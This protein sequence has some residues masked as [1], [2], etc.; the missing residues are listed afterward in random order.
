MKTHAF[1][2]S[3]NR[4]TNP[5][6]ATGDEHAVAPT[7]PG[8]ALLEIVASE[9]QE[10]QRLDRALTAAQPGMSR[11][12][13]QA[14]IDAGQVTVNDRLAKASLVLEP[15]MRIRVAPAVAVERTQ[16][17]AA[18][19]PPLRIV[20]EDAQL[21]VIDKPA[22][23]VVHPAPG[24][25]TGT[26]VDSLLAHMPDLDAGEDTT[27]PGI[28][29]RLDKDTSGLLVV[30]RD[31]ASHAALA[32]QMK[33]HETVKRYLALVEGTMTQAEGVIDAP[34]GRDPR[35]RQ[36]MGLVRVAS[37]GREARTRFRV[38]RSARGRTLLD[39]QLETGRTHQIRVHLAAVQHPVV[40]DLVYGRAQPPQPPRQF[41]H[42]AHLEFTHPLTGAWLRFEAPLPADLAA[43]VAEHFP[44]D[45]LS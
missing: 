40:G 42:A 27:R 34:I 36:R 30:A 37:G 4:D 3:P 16:V 12:R 22:G 23:V 19:A 41:L 9:Q 35:H 2:P 26:L 33:A 31:S 44:A 43:F 24:H 13:V 14:L 28:V 1:Q 25:P 10:G 8:A 15:G 7:A 38:L 17:A 32:A 39:V 20:Y 5:D 6:L 18:D 29:H 11:T 45:F 21:L